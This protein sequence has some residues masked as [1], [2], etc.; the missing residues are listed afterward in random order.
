MYLASTWGASLSITGMG[1]MPSM[2]KAGN[3]LR[4]STTVRLSMRLPPPMD[5][6]KAEEIMRE[7]LT[8]DVPY[9]AKVTLKGGLSGPGW[10][11]KELSPWLRGALDR[12]G[13]DFFG[14]PAGSYGI[15][16]SIPFLSELGQL[17]PKT[18]I[19]ALGVLGPGSNAH[20][21]NEML[22]LEYLFKLTCSLA[23]VL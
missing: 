8:T 12:A 21:P 10:C 6:K 3:V 11:M 9:G 1:G 5:P 16:G 7:K 17:Y 23:H 19:L 14:K 18:Q 2:E 4:P 20:G 13:R 22:D 15:G